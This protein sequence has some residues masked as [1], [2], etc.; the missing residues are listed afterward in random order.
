MR[1]FERRSIANHPGPTAVWW[2][3]GPREGDRDVVYYGEP[4]DAYEVQQVRRRVSRVSR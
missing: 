2:K 4:M 1:Y 3:A